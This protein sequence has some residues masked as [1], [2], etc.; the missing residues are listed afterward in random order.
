MRSGCPAVRH[1][2]RIYSAHRF[3]RIKDRRPEEF[4]FRGRM[5]GASFATNLNDR[6]NFG[7]A[8]IRGAG[9]GTRGLGSR[10]PE[11]VIQKPPTSACPCPNPEPAALSHVMSN[12]HGFWGYHASL[13]FSKI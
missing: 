2:Q 5:N 7:V 3:D 10:C 13:I 8:F 6:I 1:L 9:A 4:Y 12:S 11:Y